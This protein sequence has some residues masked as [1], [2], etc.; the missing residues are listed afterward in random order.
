MHEEL[1]SRWNIMVGKK[2]IVYHL[3]DFFITTKIEDIDSILDRLNGTIRLVRGNHDEWA[4]KIPK[5]RNAHKIEWVKDYFEHKFT[6]DGVSHL[7]VMSHFPFLA[8]NKSH[9]GSFHFHGHSHGA[10]NEVNRKYRR[11]DV[12]V[13]NLSFFPISIP[14]LIRNIIEKD[15]VFVDH[16]NPDSL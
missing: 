6:V 11:M 12:G 2:D 7:V 8:W 4:K 5:L 15:T 13:D 14:E 10:F 1:I 3:G 16:H 9:Y